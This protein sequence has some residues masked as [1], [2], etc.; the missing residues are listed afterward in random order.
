MILKYALRASVCVLALAAHH[1]VASAQTT[2]TE[3]AQAAMGTYISI[4]AVSK[5]CDFTPAKEVIDTISAN[6]RTLQ[7]I[8]GLDDAAVGGA[9][10][11]AVE[12][13]AVNKATTCAM[14]REKFDAFLEGQAA[15]AAE[16]ASG[17]GAMLVAIP[18]PNADPKKVAADLLVLAYLLE[19]IAE[20]CDS[21][22]LSDAETDRLEKAQIF[23]RGKAGYTEA[24][25]QGLSDTMEKEAT[26]GKKEFCSPAFD[27]KGNLKTVF[28]AAQ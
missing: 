3:K 14:G 2:P 15:K 8:A 20:E 11:G 16:V 19:A 24:Q 10:N 1:S 28:A 13:V 22:E 26:K 9:V 7:P 4:I 6:M 5:V 23:L 27:F 17:T 18:A 25:I 12:K 21:I